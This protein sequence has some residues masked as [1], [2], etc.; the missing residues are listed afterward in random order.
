MKNKLFLYSI[1]DLFEA[2]HEKGMPNPPSVTISVS[3][4][5]STDNSFNKDITKKK[6]IIYASPIP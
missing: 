6:T 5:P 2:P 1:I 4:F 3:S